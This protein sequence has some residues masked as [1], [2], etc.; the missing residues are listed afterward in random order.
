M[1]AGVASPERQDNMDRD[2]AARPFDCSICNN[3]RREPGRTTIVLTRGETTLVFRGVPAQICDACGD[4][5]L[6]VDVAQQLERAGEAALAAGVRYE[7]RD[8]IAAA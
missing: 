4:E 6:E 2:A 5:L 8:Y 1:G 7:V 3:G